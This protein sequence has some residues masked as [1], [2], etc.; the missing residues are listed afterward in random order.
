MRTSTRLC[1]YRTRRR[2]VFF[3]SVGDARHRSRPRSRGRRRFHRRTRATPGWEVV[4]LVAQ[5]FLL[6]R[7]RAHGTVAIWAAVV[8]A[9]T[10]SGLLLLAFGRHIVLPTPP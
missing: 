9:G 7:P 10:T 3:D 5:R 4:Q 2:R 1:A 6:V 8:A